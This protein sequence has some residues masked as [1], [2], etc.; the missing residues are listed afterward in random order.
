MVRNRERLDTC[1]RSDC[2]WLNGGR[3]WSAAGRG[4]LK[5]VTSLEGRSRQTGARAL[6]AG[7]AGASDE[8]IASAEFILSIPP[9]ADAVTLARRLVPSLRASDAKMMYVDCTP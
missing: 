2:T 5:V 4:G 3:G 9:P 7:M 6:A 1:C 8:A